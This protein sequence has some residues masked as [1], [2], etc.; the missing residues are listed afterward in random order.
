MHRD[1]NGEHL[2]YEKQRWFDPWVYL[3]L[4][5][6]TLLLA[7]IF[8]WAI[9]QQIVR[10]IPFGGKGKQTSDQGLITIVV[11]MGTILLVANV[12]VLVTRLE[13]AV[14][15]DRIWFRLFPWSRRGETLDL[16]QVSAIHVINNVSVLTGQL[17]SQ[18]PCR[19]MKG[20]RGVVLTFYQG[21]TFTIGSQ[22]P[23]A[24]AT[25]IG[26]AQANLRASSMSPPG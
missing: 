3:L 19:R 10:G 13:T 17:D 25:A 23:E 15:A 22:D 5:G 6:I 24:L 2:Y 1:P 16:R 4:L 21:G 20:R 11:V 7:A 18:N 9:V 12:L 14:T 26:T 8:T